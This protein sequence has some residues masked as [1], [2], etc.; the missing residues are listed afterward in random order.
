MR[1]GAGCAR[2][3]ALSRVSLIFQLPDHNGQYCRKTLVQRELLRVFYFSIAIMSTA[4]YTHNN[5]PLGSRQPRARGMGEPGIVSA[6]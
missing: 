3:T 2:H 5:G 4:I 6:D 1:E